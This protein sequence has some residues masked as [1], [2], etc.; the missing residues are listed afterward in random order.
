MNPSNTILP[1]LCRC[2]WP[3]VRSPFSRD[4]LW[5]RRCWQWHGVDC[6]GLENR[7]WHMASRRDLILPGDAAPGTPFALLRIGMPKTRGCAARDQAA[8]IDPPDIVSLLEATYAAYPRDK[9]PWPFSSATLR[10]RFSQLLGEI[11]LPF[12]L[13]TL[14]HWGREERHSCFSPRRTWTWSDAVAAG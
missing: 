11:G 9:K 3:C 5:L 8:R 2:F 4:G 6:L 10:R 12:D 7:L 14:D 13:L 1:Y